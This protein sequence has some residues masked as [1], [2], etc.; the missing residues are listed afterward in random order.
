MFTINQFFFKTIFF[1]FNPPFFIHYLSHTYISSSSTNPKLLKFNAVFLFAYG[2]FITITQTV[3]TLSLNVAESNEN[4]SST[5]KYLLTKFSLKMRLPFY[6][7]W[8]LDWKIKNKFLLQ[9]TC[10][11]NVMQC[12]WS[13]K[14][15][16]RIFCN[17][18]LRCFYDIFFLY[19]IIFVFV[20]LLHPL[21]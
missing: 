6:I 17:F 16:L 19:F 1:Y 3:N 14:Q 18:R 10:V 15:P 20:L 21:N 4:I 11:I 5:L 13:I 9:F 7:F 2:C 12:N 8:W